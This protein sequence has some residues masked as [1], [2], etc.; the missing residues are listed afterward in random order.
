M[1][2][3]EVGVVNGL[4]PNTT[5]VFL[6]R[7]KNS[8]GLGGP[9]PLSDLVRTL[10]KFGFDVFS[11]VL[12]W[13]VGHVSYEKEMMVMMMLLMMIQREKGINIMISCQDFVAYSC[14][15]NFQNYSQH[16][17]NT[18]RIVRKPDFRLCENKG[19]DQLRSNCEAD[20]RLCFRYSDN[21]ISLLLKSEILSF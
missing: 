14:M 11:W 3:R 13:I 21:T 6:V 18:S 10:R 17:Y 19:A 5:Y 1:Y 8:H 2:A 7:A 15:P 9:S 16:H 4:V 20:Q 12:V